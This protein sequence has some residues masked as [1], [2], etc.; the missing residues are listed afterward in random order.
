[1]MTGCATPPEEETTVEMTGPKQTIAVL[2]FNDESSYTYG[3]IPRF[4][5][6]EFLEQDLA[7]TGRFNVIPRYQWRQIIDEATLAEL[8]G[9]DDIQ[10]AAQIGKMIGAELVVVSVIYDFNVDAD[11]SASSLFSSQFEYSSTARTKNQVIDVA[12]AQSVFRQNVNGTVTRRSGVVVMS[13][14]DIIMRDSLKVAT[15]RIA[16]RIAQQL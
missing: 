7:R 4:D 9:L 1:M 3:R 12:S 15:R 13:T 5:A 6:T 14:H 10:Q 16:Q 8:G 2:K 11:R